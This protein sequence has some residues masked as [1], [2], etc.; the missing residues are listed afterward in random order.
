MALGLVL[1]GL[2]ALAARL[3]AS[4]DHTVVR[5]GWSSWRADGVIVDVPGRAERSGLRAGDVITGIAGHQ[6]TEGLGGITPPQPGDDVGYDIIRDAHPSRSTV[7]VERPNPYPFLVTGWGNL[8]F[9][10]A[11]AALA[12][13]LHLRRPEEP[14]TAPLLLTAAGLLGSTLTVVAG[15]PAL[16]LAAGGPLLWLFHLSVIGAYSVA[17]GALLAFSLLFTRHHPWLRR[18]RPAL[19]VAYAA[20]LAIMAVWTAATAGLAPDALRWLGLVHAGQT[21]VVAVTLVAVAIS[22]IVAYRHN[23]DPL[24][25]N[26]LR[27]LAGGGIL[28][29]LL[30]IAGWHLP[31]LVS[32]RQLLPAGAIGLSGLPFVAGIAVALRR[33]R[34]FDI[35]RLANRSLVYAAVVAVLAAG[36]ATAVALLVSGLR[37]SGATAAAIA[38]AAAALALAPL[39]TAAQGMVNRL[40]YGDRDDPAVVLARL[41]DRLQAVMLPGD[42]LP[43]VV[44]TVAQ[45]LRLPYAAVDL[46]DGAGGFRPVAEHGVPVGAGH[47]EPLRHHGVVVGRLRVSARG[48]DDP[49]EPADLGLIRSLARQVGPAVQAVLLHEDLLRSRAEVIALRE[50]ERRRLRRDL[51]DGLGPALAA[52]GLKAGLAAREVP[53]ESAARG[54]LSE[55]S[56]EVKSSLA[57]VQRLVEALRP[58]A[59]DELGLVGAVR[60]RA[61]TLSGELEIDVSGPAVGAQ[62]PA[63]VETAAYRIAVEA[64]TNAVRHSGGTRCVVSIATADGAVEVTVRDDGQGLGPARRAG[65]GLRSM[66]ERAAEVGGVL[67]VRSPTAAGTVVHAWLPLGFGGPVDQADP[68]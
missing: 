61:A 59:L 44:E 11:L 33:H 38:A 30:S 16:A 37:L 24:T 27:W 25:R 6:L 53:P 58:P 17:W 28:A 51:H 22:G 41:G 9:V 7:R 23:P 34:L 67:A 56:S 5:P 31:E 35:E 2:I 10:F 52:I 36:Y 49:L 20:P 60:S 50:D 21:M 32:G 14:A 13:A 65:V 42:V 40:M 15:L 64:I 47:A 66:Q 19:A 3:D 26:R 29:G 45:S 1:L 63:A 43:A 57:D 18:R 62:L 48:R 46:A 12:L 39:R 68:R 55:I 4:S 54:M 8:V